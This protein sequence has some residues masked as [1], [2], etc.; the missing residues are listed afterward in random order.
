M[1]EWAFCAWIKMTSNPYQAPVAQVQDPETSGSVEAATR[2]QRLAAVLI[3]GLIYVPIGLVAAL[4]I[5][6]LLVS[7][8][9]VGA[10]TMGLLMLGGLV[11]LLIWNLVLLVRHGQTIGK[12]AMGIGMIRSDGSVPHVLRVIFIRWFPIALVAFLLN[13]MT[14]SPIP[15]FLVQLTDA[16]FIFGPTRR[17]LHDILADTHVIR[18]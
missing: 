15:G 14:G 9:R 17:C 18:L 6:A 12:K 13:T 3:D 4:A 7:G 8:S 2:G 5:P 16:L 1:A 10:L 11:G